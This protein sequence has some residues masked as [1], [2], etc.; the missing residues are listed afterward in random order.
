M[1]FTLIVTSS[2]GLSKASENEDEALYMLENNVT[3]ILSHVQVSYL[4]LD[5]VL[6]FIGP[7]KYSLERIVA[8]Y[9]I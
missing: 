5:N 9:A 4:I 3:N 6:K 8:A 7:G 2:P 1:M